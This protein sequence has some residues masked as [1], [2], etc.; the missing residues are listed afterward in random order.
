MKSKKV[1]QVQKPLKILWKKVPSSTWQNKVLVQHYNIWR[2]Q[3]ITSVLR[4]CWGHLKESKATT[5]IQ[6]S[7]KILWKKVP[8]STWQNRVLVQHFNIWRCQCIASVLTLCWGHLWDW[9]ATTQ[10][11]KS[12][13]ILWIKVSSSAMAK[14]S[15]SAAFQHLEG[16]IHSLG[17]NTML[18]A[19]LGLECNNTSLKTIDDFVKKSAYFGYGN[20]QNKDLVWDFNIRRRQYIVSTMQYLNCKNVYFLQTSCHTSLS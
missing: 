7:L 11:Q 10:V 15:L 17:A 5:Q 2:C 19:P 6:K 8:N 9:N 1:S 3:Y 4:L 13:K 16:P 14:Q 20:W 18:K 12:L